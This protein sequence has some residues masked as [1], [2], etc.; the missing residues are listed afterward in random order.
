[1]TIPSQPTGPTPI[2]PK[3]YNI[4]RRLI[5]ENSE[6]V[7][8]ATVYGNPFIID[9]DGDRDQVCAK[10]YEWI[11]FP[12]QET[13]RTK[14]KLELKGKNLLCWCAPAK[15]HAETILEIANS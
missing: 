11:H 6:R 13:L 8:R 3:V 7:D 10:Y 9:I 4:G 15:C 1:M 12:E 2:K 14:M 5:P